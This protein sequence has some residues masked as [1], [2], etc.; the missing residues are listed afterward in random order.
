MSTA[1]EFDVVVIGAGPSGENVADRAVKGG[2]SAAIV[3][4]ALVGGECSYWACIPSKALL[5]PMHALEGARRV[6]GARQA[7]RGDVDISAALE[8]RD[9]FVSHFDDTGQ[10][11][12]LEDARIELFRGEGR[13]AGERR[14]AVET[15]SGAL[16]LIAREAVVIATG[17]IP[18]FPPVPGLK[19]AKP[20]TTHDATSV[21]MGALPSEL[22]ILGGGVA[23]CEL[24]QVFSSLGV[25]VT[26][27]EA[28][29]RLLPS[30]EPFAG[31]LVEARMG[32]LGI[33]VRTGVSVGAVSRA[34]D[35]VRV[36]L[37][38]TT[39]RADELLVATGRH[40]NTDDLGLDTV[41]LASGEW[42]EVDDSLRAI[43]VPG[44]WLYAVGDVN[45]RALLTHQGKYQARA[46]GDG[47]VAR[48]RGG[49][50][51]SAWSKCVATA[52]H[53]AVPGVVFTDPEVA[54]VGLTGAQAEELG[55]RT[56]VVDYVIGNV[57][58]AALFAD[59]YGGRA[60]LVVDDDRRV[61]IGATFVGPGA[62]ELLHAATIAIVSEVS[63][64][65]LW[66]AV[67]AFPTISEVWLRLLEAYGL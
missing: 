67:P 18:S 42:I 53:T 64:D 2:L 22:I 35:G 45:R 31:E 39:L 9:E 40:P 58:G 52:D 38:D 66:H 49:G 61:V 5:R 30:N 29:T 33:E 37:A 41:G 19:E 27:L 32:A 34:E 1:E 17:S 44:G 47:I 20:W 13:L 11:S 63:L 46:C 54:S 51:D 24:A 26:I 10:V 65:R 36:T 21:S 6:N 60:R 4:S 57:S 48:A 15:A 7:V 28:A 14:V 16:S 3:E 56:R 12:W 23:G 55:L 8:R 25:S 62:A 59:D 43:S 50:V